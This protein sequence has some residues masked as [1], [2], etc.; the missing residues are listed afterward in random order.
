[1][2]KLKQGFNRQTGWEI[3]R[4]VATLPEELVSALD[5]AYLVDLKEL[6]GDETVLIGEI[7]K[8]LTDL[9]RLSAK[10]KLTQLTQDLKEA[11]NQKDS[12][13]RKVLEQELVETSRILGYNHD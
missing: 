6:G 3:N 10:V 5:T 2:V 8:V 9:T 13:K 4:F 7:D 11:V 12:A 1:M